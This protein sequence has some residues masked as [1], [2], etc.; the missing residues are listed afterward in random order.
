MLVDAPGEKAVSQRAVRH[1]PY[2]QLR[3]HRE[4]LALRAPP[5][6]RVLALD[7]GNSLDGVRTADRLR[8]GFGKAE[9]PDLA[10]RDQIPDRA[11]D[12]FYRYI[13]IDSVLVQ[14]VDGLNAEASEG[15]VGGLPDQ[16]GAA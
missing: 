14:Q 2:A 11:R 8:S 7:C 5:P 1:E 6:E 13:W 3:T 9:V 12:L 15:G 4:H 10:L 16:L